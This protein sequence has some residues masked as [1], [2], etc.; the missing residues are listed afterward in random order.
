MYLYIL[1][2]VKNPDKIEYMTVL[3]ITTVMG[4]IF[5]LLGFSMLMVIF[6]VGPT[7]SIIVSEEPVQV[8]YINDNDNVINLINIE[9][10]YRNKINNIITGGKS[11]SKENVNYKSINYNT[12]SNDK[13]P[14]EIE[15]ANYI[16]TNGEYYH[17]TSGTTFVQKVSDIII[18]IVSIIIGI[19]F[20]FFSRKL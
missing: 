10:E 8:E 17:V 4:I 19:A 12:L 11:I 1:T 5:L 18:G 2:S 16:K 14:E 9:D 7:D 6:T 13:V 3:T 20:L 15:N